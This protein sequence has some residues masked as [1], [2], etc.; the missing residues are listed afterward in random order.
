MRICLRSTAVLLLSLLAAEAAATAWPHGLSLNT[1]ARSLPRGELV[2]IAYSEAYFKQAEYTQPNGR[3]FHVTYWD[4]QGT[5]GLRYALTDRLE[6][7][8]RQI[9]Y[10]DNHKVSPG[11]NLPDDLFLSAAVAGFGP[12]GGHFSF[13]LQLMA[14]V[15][16]AKYHN[17]VLEPYSAGRIELCTRALF[18]LTTEPGSPGRGLEMD[19]SIGLLNHNDVGKRLTAVR[20]DST[21]ARA[22][23]RQWVWALGLSVHRAPFTFGIAM[24]GNRFVQQPP[25][26]AYS[27]ESYFYLSPSVTYRLAWWLTMGSTLDIRLYEAT[28]QTAY[29]SLLPRV[30]HD[31]DNYPPWRLRV[32]AQMVLRSKQPRALRQQEVPQLARQGSPEDDALVRQLARQKQTA[33]QAEQELERIRQERERVARILE[34]LREMVAAQKATNPPPPEREKP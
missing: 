15:P 14:R 4:I 29:S 11:F 2:A 20:T 6:L 18:S 16:L 31:F 17:V 26:T 3:L 8:F 27:R 10:Q 23:S 30:G 7:G 21:V 13:G 22:S 33:E 24:S 19:G 25:V 1:T 9:L 28:D 5:V 32:F 12:A 34:K